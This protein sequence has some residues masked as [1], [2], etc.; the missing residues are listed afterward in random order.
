VLTEVLALREREAESA[1]EHERTLSAKK[2]QDFQSEL[3]QQKQMQFLY[4]DE[5]ERKLTQKEEELQGFAAHYCVEQVDSPMTP[6][7]LKC[8][9]DLLLE[10]SDDEVS[11]GPSDWCPSC[12]EDPSLVKEE[13]EKMLWLLNNKQPS[14]TKQVISLSLTLSYLCV[15]VNR[16]ACVCAI[17]VGNRLDCQCLVCCRNTWSQCMLSTMRSSSSKLSVDK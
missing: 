12:G 10:E 8:A 2:K 3:F 1:L 6:V 9:S 13:F 17:F 15:S 11:V 16:I 4:Q 7:K 5:M 14:P